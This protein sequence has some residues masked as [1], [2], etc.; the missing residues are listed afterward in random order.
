MCNNCKPSKT[1]VDI[2]RAV[3]VAKLEA[4]SN[5]TPSVVYIYNGKY[6]GEC[7]S[8]WEKGGKIGTKIFSVYPI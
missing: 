8:C 5:G 6:Y 7:K 3:K 1:A 4:E 2:D